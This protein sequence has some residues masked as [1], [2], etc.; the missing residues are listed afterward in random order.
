[1]IGYESMSTNEAA[2]RA[3]RVSRLGEFA[4]GVAHDLQALLLATA[5]YAEVLRA[6]AKNN[7]TLQTQLRPML[8][9]LEMAC[10]LV[11]QVLV[12]THESGS[13][14]RLLSIGGLVREA[15]PLMRAVVGTAGTLRLAIDAQAPLVET[16]PIDLQ[17]ALLNLV[18]NASRAIRQPDGVIEVGVTGMQGADGCSRFVRITVADNGG[19][20]DGAT[21][22]NWR[23]RLA[24]S[25]SASDAAGLGLGMVHRVVCSH[26][27]RIRLDSQMGA[28]STVRI[29]LPAMP[30]ALDVDGTQSSRLRLAEAT[31]HSPR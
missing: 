10:N 1:M 30:R 29:D 24:D 23:R 19:G 22:D 6:E 14:R 28:G 7:P 15:L 26:G 12:F 3:H 9:T 25:P 5:K 4:I 20:M 18:C 21:L 17:R 13:E 31:A 8:I 11:D 16:D 2:E 27:G